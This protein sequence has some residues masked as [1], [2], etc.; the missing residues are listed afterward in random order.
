VST[1]L[2]EGT[3]HASG[4]EEFEGAVLDRVFNYRRPLRRPSAVLEAVSS[5][6]VV[7]GV[8][9]AIERSWKVAVRS[10]GH[11]WAAWSVRD[12]ALLI[13]L[14]G[15]HELS[16]D[17]DTGIATAS[18]STTGEELAHFLA[19]YGRMFPG[20][21]CPT[22]GIG[23]FLLQGGQG[24]NARGWGWAAQ[25]VSA[26]DVVTAEGELVRADEFVHPDLYWA[27]R[28]GGPGFFGVV[29]RFHLRTLPLP[30][31]IRQSTQAYAMRHYDVVMQW[32][33]EIQ[34]ELPD[35]VEA[36]ALAATIPDLGDSHVILVHGLTLSES[37]EQAQSA[38]APFES[39]PALDEALLHVAGVTT[40]FETEYI[41]QYQANPS[42][43]RY[44]VDNAWINQTHEVAVAG[45]RRAFTELPTPKS[46]SLW[47]SMDPLRELPDMAFSLQAP[48]Y[49]ACYLV[50][51]DERD[52][53]R[54]REWLDVT[55]GEIEKIAEGCYLGDS[56]FSR[57]PARF[58]SDE[59]WRRF[60]AIRE[61]Y[62]PTGRFVGYLGSVAQ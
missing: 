16:F 10:G 53:E 24:W 30:A 3:F 42:G 45:L 43:H 25:Y 26:I 59:A 23:G 9:L 56:D 4:D 14:G 1:P 33:A 31:V 15:L 13:D 37:E 28:G 22:V 12:D 44:I 62:D 38:L 50:H 34:R 61:E 54:S 11:S 20:G 19:P 48:V 52:D 29:V 17:A 60:C 18:P 35:T 6:D 39:C 8:R 21:H 57:R 32:F 55:M 2:F 46:F 58:M 40:S 27:A 49:F 51:E 41:D 5:D 47:F 7:M 36:V